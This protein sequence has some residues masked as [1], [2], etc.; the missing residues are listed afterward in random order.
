VALVQTVNGEVDSDSLGFTLMHEHL[1]NISV[2][3]YDQWPHLIDMS[4]VRDKIILAVEAAYSLGVRTVVDLTTPNLGRNVALMREV[5][6]ATGMN[7]ICATGI[8]PLFP[9]PMLLDAVA[10]PRA[11][12]NVDEVADLFVHDIAVG[13]AGTGIRAGMIKTGTDPYLDKRSEACLRASARAHRRTGVPISTHTNPQNKVGL[14]Q[15]DVFES[16][17]VDLSRVVIGHCGDSD[18]I[19]YLSAICNR[20]SFVGMDRFGYSMPGT[21]AENID[22]ERRVRVVKSMCD[23]GFADRIVVSHDAV[24]WSDIFADEYRA[25]ALPDWNLTYIESEVIP[26]MRR[27]EIREADIV[28][29]TILNPRSVFDNSS[30]Y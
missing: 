29:M 27:S 16:E 4:S 8:H 20:G 14:V 11:E 17:G 5:A 30:I 12:M 26:L 19:E 10:G 2:G 24:C 28:K 7:V 21:P 13:I 18:D 23:R 22:V 25:A 15:Q 3:M 9:V 1:A 6:A